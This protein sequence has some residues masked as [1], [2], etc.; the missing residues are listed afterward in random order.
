M[1]KPKGIVYLVGAGPGDPGLITIKG[2]KCVENADVVIYDYL[3]GQELLKYAHKNAEIIY[4]GKRGGHHT[5]PQDSINSLIIQKAQSGLRV[6]RLKGGDPFIFGRG[7]EEAEVLIEKEIPFE[8]VPGVTSAIAAPAY[9]GIPLTHRRFTSSVVFITGHEDPTKDGSKINWSAIA[10]GTGTIVILMGVKN[11]P[12]I[13]SLLMNHGRPHDTP[14]ALVRWGTTTR[15]KTVTG[16]LGNI[17]ERVK[18]AGLKPPSVIVVG[19]V[20]KLRKSMKWFE[21]RPLLGKKVVVTRTRQ[22]SSKL[23]KSLSDL[24]AICMECPTIEVVPTDDFGPLDRA[25]DNLSMFDWLVFTS[26]NSVD[27]FF[28]RMFERGFDAR[29]LNGLRTASIGPIAAKKLLSFG[30]KNDITPESYSGESITRAFEKEAIR[31]K[32]VLVP[33][34][35]DEKAILPLELVK[36]GADVEEVI[37]Y[38]TKAARENTDILVDWLENGNVDLVTFTSSSTVKNFHA[39]LPPAK[40]QTLLKGITIASIGPVTTDTAKNLGFDVHVTAESFTIPGLCEAVLKYYG[41]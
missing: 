39:L 25:I 2:K 40:T 26:V 10:R 14:V 3:A 6:V 31:G 37:A 12:K 4:V 38:R 20:V 7:G 32:K 33:R 22:Q 29:N 5:M 1:A 8:I 34:A 41:F 27:F 9:A 16:T 21:N 23:V 11:L 24:G 17:V 35:R 19:D 30:I 36:L 15:Q 13:V 28:N 18:T